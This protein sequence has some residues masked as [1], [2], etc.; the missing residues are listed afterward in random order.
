MNQNPLRR[1]LSQAVWLGLVSAMTFMLWFSA[2]HA[3]PSVEEPSR[4]ILIATT[5]PSPLIPGQ[6]NV[7]PAALATLT[8]I[9][10]S[11]FPTLSPEEIATREAM[12]NH[13][14]LPGPTISSPAGQVA[15][16]EPNTETTPPQATPPNGENTVNSLVEKAPIQTGL[17]VAGSTAA[18]FLLAKFLLGLALLLRGR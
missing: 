12:L 14:Y 3:L 5:F 2:V 13:T 6:S 7:G 8:I 11:S 10:P 4:T 18:L 15:G 16:P 17:A 1:L 9:D